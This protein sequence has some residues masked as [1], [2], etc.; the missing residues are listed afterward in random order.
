MEYPLKILFFHS[1]PY[2]SFIPKKLLLWH[3]ILIIDGLKC[4]I[5]EMVLS[6]INDYQG[7]NFPTIVQFC[8]CI[9]EL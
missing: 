7:S 9:D 6:I 3:I 8:L 4:S 2:I 1:F 5:I